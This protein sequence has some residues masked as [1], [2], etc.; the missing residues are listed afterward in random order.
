MIPKDERRRAVISRARWALLGAALLVGVSMVLV[1]APARAV[2][3][4]QP[5]PSV[6]FHERVELGEPGKNG[7]LFVY[8]DSGY[9]VW[10]AL[11]PNGNVSVYG[12]PA[13][14]SGSGICP[15]EVTRQP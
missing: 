4:A 15:V 2:H 10:V 14:A 3:R 9:R 8:C 6:E 5:E 12:L 13:G 11:A 1:L 7:A